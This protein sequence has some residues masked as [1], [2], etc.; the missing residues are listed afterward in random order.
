MP[1]IDENYED[2]PSV[3]TR[4][5][6][7]SDNM[8][9]ADGTFDVCEVSSN[10]DRCNAQ[11]CL[12]NFFWQAQTGR[13]LHG[14]ISRVR[15]DSIPK[16]TG[17]SQG[18]Y[19]AISHKHRF[20]FVHVLK[21]GGSETRTFLKSAL[22]E[23]DGDSQVCDD[24]V[25]AVGSCSMLMSGYPSYFRWTWARSVSARAVSVYGMAKAFGMKQNI[26]LDEFWINE[27]RWSLTSL[28]PDHARPQLDFLQDRNGCLALD[29]VG[30]LENAH[31]DMKVIIDI[32][33]AGELRSHYEQYGFNRPTHG[34]VFGST[35]TETTH[36]S[37]QEMVEANPSLKEVLATVYKDD[38]KLIGW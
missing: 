5:N 16:V 27:N 10:G 34:N 37:A 9:H 7:T 3:F 14:K 36:T 1:L 17:N 18:S 13:L 6:L 35:E 32:L 4:A 29:F 22:C 30:S 20:I 8:S 31:I 11:P 21:N 26:S 38:V 24:Q 12:G 28:S 33:N 15:R 19:C 25:I 23:G 2:T